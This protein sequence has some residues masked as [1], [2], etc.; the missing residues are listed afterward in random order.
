MLFPLQETYLN[1]IASAF[2]A[3]KLDT[4]INPDEHRSTLY[5]ARK[6]T[7]VP[8]YIMIVVFGV[9]DV[10]LNILSRNERELAT[11]IKFAEGI[12]GFLHELRRFMRAD[13]IAAPK[14][15]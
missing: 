2:E 5:A 8:E 4:L 14:A 13:R 11:N 15:A 3:E 7:T 10:S 1:C 12:D 6:G 9:S